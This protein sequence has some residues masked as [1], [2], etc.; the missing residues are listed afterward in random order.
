VTSNGYSM[1][2]FGG[3]NGFAASCY[4]ANYFVFGNPGGTSDYVCVQGR[5]RLPASI[6]DGLSN[7]IFFSEVYASCGLWGDSSY[8][9]ASLWADSTL[10][11]RAI[12]CHNTTFKNVNPGYAPCNLFQVQPQMFTT[13][14][15]S[16]PQTGHTAG[17]NAALGDG[18]VRFISQSISAT[19]W[20][21]ACDPQDGLPLGPDW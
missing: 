14:D 13:C 4:A 3:A 21:L 8:A 9:A 7:T 17:I 1:T 15:P 12:M 19:T 16:R 6:P 5:N 18:S 11:W 2:V 20:A 10:P